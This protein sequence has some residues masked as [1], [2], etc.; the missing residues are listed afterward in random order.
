V[1]QCVAGQ[2][3][4]HEAKSHH[5]PVDLLFTTQI[6]III[7]IQTKSHSPFLHVIQERLYEG[8]TLISNPKPIANCLEAHKGS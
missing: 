2:G 6:T 7:N 4:K 1:K 5:D 3:K 8:E